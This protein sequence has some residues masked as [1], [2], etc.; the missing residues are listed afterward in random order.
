MKFQSASS[1]KYLVSGVVIAVSRFTL[2]HM[3]SGHK[4]ALASRVVSFYHGFIEVGIPCVIQSI[5][6]PE[7]LKK[8]SQ[9]Y[10][11]VIALEWPGAYIHPLCN[12]ET[13]EAL[14]SFNVTA[15]HTIESAFKIKTSH[16]IWTE[17]KPWLDVICTGERFREH[18]DMEGFSLAIEWYDMVLVGL[19]HQVIPFRNAMR[20][21]YEHHRVH[22]KFLKLT[23]VLYSPVPVELS[24][25]QP[26]S[27]PLDHLRIFFDWDDR[28]VIAK[29]Q[30]AK[31]ILGAIEI[32]RSRKDLPYQKGVQVI[33]TVS[34]PEELKNYT[35][36]EILSRAVN[37]LINHKLFIDIISSCHI[38][39]TAIKSSYENPV[40]ESQM[41]GAMLV[42]LHEIMFFLVYT[43]RTNPL[44]LLGFG[45]EQCT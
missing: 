20:D 38:Y 26:D 8:L 13:G 14:L 10:S 28:G 45:T 18:S 36:V 35:T 15:M 19:E 6:N 1:M 29:T 11:H 40:V 22:C 33:S 30:V 39:A 2:E 43:K 17:E 21:M 42:S 5:S 44:F 24:F 31:A 37:G 25:W 9:S 7:Q 23:S 32:L 27:K 34:L 4:N 3:E 12:Q 16:M 41:G